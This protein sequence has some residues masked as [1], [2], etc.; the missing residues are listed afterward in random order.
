MVKMNIPYTSLGLVAGVPSLSIGTRYHVT[1]EKIRMGYYPE[2]GVFKGNI[3]YY[4]G[5]G[6]SML[7]HAPL[8]EKLSQNGYRVIAF[9]YMGQG[10][11][12]GKWIERE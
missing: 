8:F 5:L 4:E 9:D 3:L 10:G 6:D 2:Q 12:S 7:N 11:S 1:R